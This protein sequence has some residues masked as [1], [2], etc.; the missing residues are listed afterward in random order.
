MTLSNWIK[1]P[2]RRRRRSFDSAAIMARQGSLAHRRRVL[3]MALERYYR[4]EWGDACRYCG[5][6]AECMDHAYP[7]SA[8][9]KLSHPREA[10]EAMLVKVPACTRCNSALGD[11]VFA[12]MADR[13]K[14]ARGR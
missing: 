2:A 8:L 1:V 13:I 3:E 14:F 11:R 12:T 6:P 4:S 9:A 10:P 7:L 5:R